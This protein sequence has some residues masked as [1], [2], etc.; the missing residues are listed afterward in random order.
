M[1]DEFDDAARAA[2]SALRSDAARIA[3]TELSLAGLRL[4]EARRESGRV[5][6]ARPVR[7][8]RA[9]QATAIV[10]ALVGTILFLA[11]STAR[12]QP[13][14]DGS[15]EVRNPAAAPSTTVDVAVPAPVIGTSGLPVPTTANLPISTTAD[16]QHALVGVTSISFATPSLGWAIAV[17]SGALSHFQVLKTIDGGVSWTPTPLAEGAPAA[18]RGPAVHFADPM[19]GWVFGAALWST[20]DGGDTWHRVLLHG[21]AAATNFYYGALASGAG[22]VHVA[23]QGAAGT[24]IYSSPVADDNFAPSSPHFGRSGTDQAEPIHMVVSGDTGFLL[25]GGVNPLN[26]LSLQAGLWED[27][28]PPCQLAGS[29]AIG[30]SGSSVAVLCTLITGPGMAERLFTSHDNGSSFV[31]VTP[32]AF[33]ELN[34]ATVTLPAANTLLVT[35]TTA[36]GPSEASVLLASFDDGVSWTFQDLPG[37]AGAWIDLDFIDES[38]AVGVLGNG[39]VRTDDGGRSWTALPAALT[40]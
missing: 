31:D 26:G 17:P 24:T 36:A 7:R 35:G 25:S 11:L 40:S 9:F 10:A 34:G 21:D 5:P 4:D 2:A 38:H 19:N 23:V 6:R 18:T 14:R 37:S 30:A 22:V 12:H 33:T 32:A 1:S 16:G 28:K 39:L 13:N 15:A 3:R 29:V 20:H 27:W 8:G